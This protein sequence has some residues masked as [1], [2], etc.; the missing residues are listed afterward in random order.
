[1]E[2]NTITQEQQPTNEAGTQNAPEQQQPQQN[3]P[4]FDQML[5]NGYQAEFDRRVAKAIQTASSKFSD[6]RVDQLKG[7]LDGY[8]RREAVLKANVDPQFTD[9]VTYSVGQQLG[10][11]G[12]F[13]AKLTEFLT[14]NPQ[15]VRQAAAPQP[16]QPGA[17]GQHQTGG[18]S[19]PV[20]GVEAAFYKLNP[21]LRNKGV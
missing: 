15:Y 20:D 4:T 14:A 2:E 3:R 18:G 6:P 9:F 8:I 19:E 7:Q 17:W 13:S 10:E 5:Q 11:S 12:D 1:M 16:Q 21:T